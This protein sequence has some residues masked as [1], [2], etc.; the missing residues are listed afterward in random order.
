[1]HIPLPFLDF[2][3]PIIYGQI[4]INAKRKITN[5]KERSKNRVD[6]QKSIKELKVRIRL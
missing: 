4:L 3:T 2:I 6:W 5:W 1:M